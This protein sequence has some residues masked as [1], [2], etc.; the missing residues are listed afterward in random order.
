M[1]NKDLMAVR[2]NGLGDAPQYKLDV[3]REQAQAY[4]VSI[5]DISDTIQGALASEYV[6]QFLRGDRVKDVYVQGEADTRMLPS[7]LGKW[8][9]RNA[10]GQMVPLNSFVNGHWEMGPQKV[11]IYNGRTA[12]EIQGEAAPGVSSGQAMKEVEDLVK[13]LPPGVSMEWTGLSYEEAQAGSQ[14]LALYSISII[15][16]LLCLAALYESWSIPIAVMMVVP[17]GII[18]AVL[19][20]HIRGIDNDVYFQVGLLTTMGLAVK[21]AILIVEFALHFYNNGESLVEAAIHAGRERLRPILMTSIAFICGTFPLA[22]A[23]GAGAGAREAIGTAVVGG[24]F[25]ATILAIFFVPIFFVSIL[26]ISKVKPRPHKS[27][28]T[29]TG[30]EG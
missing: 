12:Y 3:D 11:E 25:T 18:G 24:M 16:V 22:I 17:L 6:D 29:P 26:T 5:A 14:T 1:K 19:A 28:T 2:P 8:Y 30:Q 21:N 23:T 10:S 20:N 9:I 15:F 27:P 7:D 13:K 4:G